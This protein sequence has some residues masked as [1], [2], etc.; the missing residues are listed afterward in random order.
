MELKVI[1]I[2]RKVTSLFLVAFIA[3]LVA[4]S[5]MIPVKAQDLSIIKPSDVSLDITNTREDS[6]FSVPGNIIIT[7]VFSQFETSTISADQLYRGI[8]FYTVDIL[9]FNDIPY[10]YLVSE[11]GEIYEG[12]QGGEER[13]I[14]INGIGDNLVVIGYMTGKN[15]GRFTTQAKATLK[16]LLLKIA[17]TH[18]VEPGESIRV[19][20]SKFVRDPEALS[21]SIEREDLFG[22]W[23]SD[24]LEI[25]NAVSIQYAPVQKNY[26]AKINQVT[27]PSQEVVPG[28]EVTISIDISNVGE[29]GMYGA[30][31]SELILTS[32]RGGTS[33]FFLNN[34]WVSTTQAPLMEQGEFLL[35][36]ENKTLDFQVRAPLSIGEVTETFELYTLNGKKVEANAIQIGL[37]MSRPDKPIIEIGNTETGNL[38]VRQTPSSVA[39]VVT[40]VSPGERFFVVSNAGNGWIEIDLGGS[41]GWIA[42]WYGRYL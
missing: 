42:E 17:N 23:Q 39:P 19:E 33:Q 41:T 37:F 10:H 9:G 25:R 31:D 4:F 13:K 29:H 24:L 40:Q 5:G 18:S 34:S 27:A 38:N 14:R 11:D 16:N 15:S 20:G 3:I 28:S 35:P 1:T 6:N 30:S 22:S 2:F 36:F 21:V 7:P 12:N 8:Y 32:T 26:I